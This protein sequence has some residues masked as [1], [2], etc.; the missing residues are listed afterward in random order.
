MSTCHLICL[1]Q[2]EA[3]TKVIYQSETCKTE[4]TFTVRL[5]AAAKALT[6]TGLVFPH[7][8]QLLGLDV[9]EALVIRPAALRGLGR[10]Q[11]PV[12]FNIHKYSCTSSIGIGSPPRC[13]SSWSW[14][15]FPVLIFV[16]LSSLDFSWFSASS[17]PEAE[18][19]REWRH[20]RASGNPGTSSCSG[21]NSW[22][23]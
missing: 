13:S 18:T 4:F 12:L 11:K 21:R 22:K 20:R 16:P 17:A 19:H 9:E 7:Q 10:L 6:Q 5:V 1:D 23:W 2:S 14:F 15:L 3:S 8:S